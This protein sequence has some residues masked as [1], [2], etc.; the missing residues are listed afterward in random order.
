MANRRVSPLK[1]TEIKN[2]KPREKE[3]SLPDGNGLQLLIKTD[4]QLWLHL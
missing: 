1:D 2:A 4:W 3:Y